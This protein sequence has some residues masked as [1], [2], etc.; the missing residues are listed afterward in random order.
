MQV[1]GEDG[2]TRS[3]ETVAFDARANR[4]DLIDQRL[5]PHRLVILQSHGHADTARA[6]TDMVVR[7][8]IAIGA[9]AAFGYAQGLREFSG[10]SPEDFE[11][12]ESRVFDALADARP[13]AVDPL[14]VLK[15]LRRITESLPSIG[16]RQQAALEAAVDYAR[17]ITR[18]CRAIGEQGAALFGEGCRVMTHCNA[19]WLACLDHG[20]AT[21]PLYRARSEG[22]S[23]HVY[24][25]ET[26]PRSQG[27]SLTAWEMDQAGIPHEVVT[28]NACGHL[29]QRGM[30]DAVI[31][32]SDRTLAGTGE[33]AN[34]I[35]TYMK[36]VLARRHDIPFY[37][38]I[39]LSTL[40]WELARGTDIPIED[41]G[42]EEVCG[43]RG[44]NESGELVY[45]RVANASSGALNPGF[46]V[47]PPDLITG[48]ITPRGI[49]A[50][51]ELR[52]HETEL[53]GE[54]LIPDRRRSGPA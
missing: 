21:S 48:I 25:S 33:V 26:R 27:A 35:G 11:R 49:F 24:C 52:E 54:G 10:R 41:R 28:D 7:G 17:D 23:L 44:R 45:V 3:M 13:T 1:L 6:I 37:V 32:G 20:T 15:A 31:V 19:G 50:P 16:E 39:P 30:V 38:A 47:T 34:K 9:T 22:R 42:P 4:V 18:Q 8:A 12:H 43:A 2:G 51:S 14:N 29:M 40:D 46:D 5:L 53:R 36:A